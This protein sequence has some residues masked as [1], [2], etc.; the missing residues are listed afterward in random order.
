[1][2]KMINRLLAVI[3]ALALIAGAVVIIVEVIAKLVGAQPVLV[4][5]PAALAWAGR[6]RWD[7]TAVKA[8]G[9][10]LLAVGLILTVF[11]LWPSR[12]RRLPVDSGDPSMEAAVTRRGVMQDV[13]SAVD[14]V[15]GVTPRRVAVRPGRVRVWATSRMV[16]QD[17][18]AVRD[19]VAQSVG[20]HLDRLQLRRR[21]R[22]AVSVD[23]RS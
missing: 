12:A 10:L 5:W 1:M 21:P 11:E 15:D 19:A 16:D 8:T 6:T 2:R 22:L 14:E 7:A 23:R 9:L 3:A 18:P 17:R 13:K 20:T 4:D